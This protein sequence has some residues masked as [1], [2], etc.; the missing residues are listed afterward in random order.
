M[1]DERARE[2][3]RLYHEEDQTLQQIGDRYG[4]TRERV[5]QILAEFPTN[6]TR[7]MVSERA[8]RRAD[9]AAE[10]EAEQIVH[11]YRLGFPAVRIAGEIPGATPRSVMAV[12][13][14]SISDLERKMIR[15][16]KIAAGKQRASEAEMLN[17]LDRAARELG[18]YFGYVQF[19]EWA[20]REGVVG[21]QTYIHR[22][23]SWAEARRRVG[24]PTPS[25]GRGDR[26][27]KRTR[28]ECLAAVRA[29]ADELGH[30]PSASEYKRFRTPEMPSLATVRW[31][32]GDGGWAEALA[33]IAE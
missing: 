2:M 3:R 5:R 14:S 11:L 15:G 26:S 33:E 21:P 9:R 22:F 13:R 23:G 32:L 4:V 19:A 17:N 8:Q 28:E 24:L 16:R 20:K 25:A 27:D 12:I 30:L 6:G 7:R 18:E 1:V 29:A 31:R 10:A